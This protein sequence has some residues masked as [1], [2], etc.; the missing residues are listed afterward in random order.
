M[1]LSLH[2]PSHRQG[3]TSL[4]GA[5]WPIAPSAEAPAYLHMQH[6]YRPICICTS[7]KQVDVICGAVSRATQAERCTS[8]DT[9]TSTDLC[10]DGLK[11]LLLSKQPAL[12]M[13]NA[14]LLSQAQQQCWDG[15][16]QSR[17][18]RRLLRVKLC[19]HCQ[20]AEG[21]HRLVGRQ[22]A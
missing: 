9:V 19:A 17:L 1:Y 10:P 16:D 13:E 20:H 8:G 2:G 6:M 4:H 5:S 7:F 22:A 3:S 15:L 21:G 18:A 11:M 14:I 12:P